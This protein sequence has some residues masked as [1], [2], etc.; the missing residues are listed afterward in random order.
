MNLIVQVIDVQRPRGF[1][2]SRWIFRCLLLILAGLLASPG[3]AR[4]EDLLIRNARLIDGTGAAPR[5][6]QSVLIRDGRIDRI[7]AD[8]PT[9]LA[10]VLDVRGATLLPG[11]ID[12]HVH[13]NYAPGSAYRDDS[14]QTIRELNHQHLKAYLACGVTTVLDAG[15]FPEIA[16]D[17]ED[18]LASGHPGPRYLTLG[19]YIRMPRGYGHAKFGSVSSPEDVEAELDEIQSL[20]G[21][22]IKVAIEKGFNPFSRLQTFPPEIRQ[23][24]LQGAERRKLPIYVHAMS[25]DAQSEALDLGAHALM[26]LAMT[27]PPLGNWSASRD[28]SDAFVERM[29]HSG[30]YQVTTLSVFDTWPG[31][32]DVTRL[33]D[34]LTRLVVPPAEIETAQAADAE[35]RFE[36]SFVGGSVA[37]SSPAWMRPWIARAF[38]SPSHVLQ[39]L[40][41]GKRNLRRL[42]RAG[43]PIVAGTDAPSPWPDAIYH[44]HGVQLAREIELLAEAGMPPPDAIASATRGPAR[45]LGLDR[46]IGTVEVGKRADLLIVRGDPLAD[47]RALH[48]V[49]WTIKDGVAHS[50]AEWMTQ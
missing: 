13:F 43:V 47:L 39:G 31:V 7:A 24:I 44:F 11:L 16:R 12:S 4:G 2:A 37:P 3:G 50:P 28:L 23:A 22:G 29:A 14:P 20:H 17:I 38:I 40:Q 34:S 6:G 36:V 18:W 30:A 27:V 41:Q 32:Y 5:D 21:V 46:E 35:Y 49:L 15:A 9:S 26:H 48:T 1:S 42:Y 10:Q 45:M 33:D 8:L 19:P 25:E